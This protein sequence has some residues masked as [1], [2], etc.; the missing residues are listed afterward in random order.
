MSRV[1]AQIVQVAFPFQG[2]LRMI[3]RKS[4]GQRPA[5]VNR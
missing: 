2:E 5:P 4:W 1:F 3:I